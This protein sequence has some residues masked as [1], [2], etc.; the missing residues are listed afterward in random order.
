MFLKGMRSISI[1]PCPMPLTRSHVAFACSLVR[2]HGRETMAPRVV[3]VSAALAVAVAVAFVAVV[4]GGAHAQATKMPVR[5]DGTFKIITFAD[6][7][8]SRGEDVGCDA[9]TPEQVRA[10]ERALSAIRAW[11][12]ALSAVRAWERALSAVRGLGAGMIR[13]TRST[14]RLGGEV[15]RMDTLRPNCRTKAML[16]LARKRGGHVPRAPMRALASKRW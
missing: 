13:F 14:P 9:L 2:L 10:W 3:S 8:F 7:H 16:V 4:L 12:R 11:E 1:C 5:A 15:Q 6:M